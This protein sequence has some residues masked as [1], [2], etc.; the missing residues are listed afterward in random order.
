MMVVGLGDMVTVGVVF[1]G[2]AVIV[3]CILDGS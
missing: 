1:T 3:T 2:A